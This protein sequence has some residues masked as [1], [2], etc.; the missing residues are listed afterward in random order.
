M[1]WRKVYV[2]C[3]WPF[4]VSR[5]RSVTTTVSRFESSGC[6]ST[7]ASTTVPRTMSAAR[8]VSWSRLRGTVSAPRWASARAAARL[9]AKS[10]TKSWKLR[11]MVSVGILGPAR[12]LVMS[13]REGGEVSMHAVRRP[14]K[15]RRS[16]RAELCPDRQVIRADAVEHAKP[17]ELDVG[18]REHVVDR[19]AERPDGGP[20]RADAVPITGVAQSAHLHERPVAA[21]PHGDVE[22]AR[23]HDRICR[24]ARVARERQ[25]LRVAAPDHVRAHRRDGVGENDVYVAAWRRQRRGD[26][27]RRRLAGQLQR[28]RV[29]EREP[30]VEREA[31]MELVRRLVAEGVRR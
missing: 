26:R 19:H 21:V 7:R 13:R 29:L 22:V 15:P 30:A 16:A 3:A 25:D 5:S 2:P 24:R 9:A 20:G 10:R 1:Y 18:R 27:A 31:G 8:S 4:S 17:A 28:A 6:F 11:R 14:C 12:S 23:H